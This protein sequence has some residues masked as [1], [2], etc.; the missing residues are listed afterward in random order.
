MGLSS[1]VLGRFE[2]AI[3]LQEKELRIAEEFADRSMISHALWCVAF[4]H[5]Y[6]GDY[7]KA[8]ETGERAVQLAP[9]I[10]ERAWAE[11]ALGIAHCRSGDAVKGLEILSRI[12][13]GFRAAKFMACEAFLSYLAEGY[14]R[15]GDWRRQELC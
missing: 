7:I 2:R 12:M 13:P 8:D 11:G 3:E 15:I 10:A 1:S 14:C 5:G 4:D 6:R 9:T